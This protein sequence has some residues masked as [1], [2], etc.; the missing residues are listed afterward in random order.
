VHRIFINKNILILISTYGMIIDHIVF[1]NT[2]EGITIFRLRVAAV[3]E[4]IFIPLNPGELNPVDMVGEHFAGFDIHNKD[5]IPV[6]ATAGD[7]IGQI[8]T[9]FRHAQSCQGNGTIVREGIGVEQQLTI[10]IVIIFK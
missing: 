7:T 10:T 8:F 3:E 9:I 5:F 2:F 6:G 1:V 4:A